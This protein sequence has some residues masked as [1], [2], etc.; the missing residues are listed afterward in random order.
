MTRSL[1]ILATILL[2]GSCVTAPGADDRGEIWWVFFADKGPRAQ[3]DARLLGQARA[4]SPDVWARRARGGGAA[5]PDIHDAP[6][7]EPY[8]D[9]AGEYGTLRHRSRWLNAVS[10]RLSPSGRDAVAALPFVRE[11]RPVAVAHRASIGPPVGPVS[12]IRHRPIDSRGRDLLYGA[13]LGQLTEIDV[14][15]VHALGFTGNRVRFMML[16]TGFR[17][18]HEAFAQSHILDAWDFVFGDGEVQNEPDDAENQHNHGTSTWGAAGGFAPDVCIG[19]GYGATFVLA[20]TEDIRSETRAEEDNYVAAL[21][22]AD[23]LGVVLT[24]ASLNYVCFDDDFCYEYEDKDGDTAVITRAV[25]IAAS[26]GIL[27]VNS[28][29]NYGQGVGTLGTPADADSMV[30]VGAV[31]SLNQITGFSA[32]GPT[33]DGRTK[34]EVVARG[35][36]TFC[37]HA[38]AVDAYTHTSGTSLSTPLVSGA[39]ALLLEAHPEWGPMDAREALLQTADR[40]D[41]PDNQYGW[42]RISAASAIEWTPVLYPMPFSLLDPPDS[43]TA[44]TSRPTLLWR[45][46]DDPDAEEPITYVIEIQDVNGPLNLWHVDAGTDTSAVLSFPLPADGVY[47]WEVLAEDRDG[48]RRTS[49]ETFTLFGPPASSVPAAVL[50]GPRLTCSPNPFVSEVRFRITSP[51]DADALEWAVYD[52]L[53]RRVATGHARSHDGVFQAEWDGRTPEGRRGHPGVYFLEARIGPQLV[54]E[55]LLLLRD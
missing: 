40:A 1:C 54:R 43:S 2:L 24:S 41:A 38:S 33:Y 29:G 7:W 15:P 20:K 39:T 46:S 17:K 21:E 34:P 25:D 35:L 50:S 3:D 42:G 4:F 52:P 28:Q 5:M 9:A 30:A 51:I 53:G 22:M 36:S 14:P 23:A 32:S 48:Y 6:L 44:T 16:D 49:R 18:D 55:T 8:V 26:R 10:M 37:P 47:T 19:P 31:D 11:V 13:S 27:C 45:A 12:E